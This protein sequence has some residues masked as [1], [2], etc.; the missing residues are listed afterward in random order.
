MTGIN[1]GMKEEKQRNR[2]VDVDDVHTHYSKWNFSFFLIRIYVF[3][4]CSSPFVRSLCHF[5]TNKFNSLRLLS[6]LRL[7]LC[8]CRRFVDSWF[9]HSALHS[10]TKSSVL[11][12]PHKLIFNGFSAASERSER[13][14]DIS[15]GS[16]VLCRICNCIFFSSTKK[17]KQMEIGFV[18]RRH[19]SQWDKRRWWEDW[20]TST[21][22]CV[23]CVRLS[24]LLTRSLTHVDRAAYIHRIN[25]V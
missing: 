4:L 7:T 1:F 10:K 20:L 12:L 6:L 25:L 21:I 9:F 23:E 24:H 2:F 3:S 19:R 11:W 18:S 14:I 16:S 22:S 13:K 5:W 17:M 15:S 8:H